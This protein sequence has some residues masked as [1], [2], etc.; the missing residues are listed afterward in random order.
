M[1]FRSQSMRIVVD[2]SIRPGDLDLSLVLDVLKSF[3]V[4]EYVQDGVVDKES[5]RRLRMFVGSSNR[6]G[7]GL[8][9]LYVCNRPPQ[10]FAIALRFYLF[11]NPRRR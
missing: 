5:L 4:K 6:R 9:T 11:R 7:G 1:W 10:D 3:E 8:D 2:S